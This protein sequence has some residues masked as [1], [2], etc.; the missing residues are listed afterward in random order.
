[1]AT[2]KNKYLNCV[3]ESHKIRKKQKLLDKHV[4]KRDKINFIQDAYSC[5]SKRIPRGSDEK[6]RDGVNSH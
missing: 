4:E 3:I 6:N 1:M 5:N 2:D